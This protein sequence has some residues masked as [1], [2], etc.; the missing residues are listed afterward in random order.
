MAGAVRGGAAGRGVFITISVASNKGVRSWKCSKTALSLRRNGLQSLSSAVVSRERAR[1]VANL[2][3][4]SCVSG[5]LARSHFYNEV[6]EAIGWPPDARKDRIVTTT[7]HMSATL[8]YVRDYLT[9]KERA[10][11]KQE[12]FMRDD[13]PLSIEEARA[14]LDEMELNG[15]RYVT[16]CD[17]QTAE[18]RCAGHE[19]A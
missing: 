6:C 13:E 5:G 19:P 2:S 18:G 12:W 4:G 17:N 8:G 15:L 9:D 14:A 16:G 7:M 11:E 10:G 3:R 1:P